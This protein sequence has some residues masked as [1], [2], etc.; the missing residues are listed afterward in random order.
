MPM[1]TGGFA[2]LLTKDFEKIFFDE[3]LRQPEEYRGVA[4]MQTADTHYIREGDMYGLGALREMAE[5][6]PIPFEDFEQ[7]NEKYTYFT[8]FGLGVQMS[9]NMYEDDLTGHMNKPIAEL[10]KASAYTRDLKFWDIFNSG[11]LAAAR[12]GLD[13]L[14]LFST[15]HPIEGVPGLT[16]SN[17]VS[18]S[19][20]QTS[21][22]AAMDLV[23]NLKNDK[24]I[25]IKFIPRTLVVPYGQRWKAEELINSELQPDTANNN[26]NT[27]G[28]KGLNF[29]VGHYLTDANACYLVCDGHDARFINRR[30]TMFDGKDDYNTDAALFKATARFQTTFFHWR[31]IVKIT[32]A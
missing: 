32:G 30:D 12:V 5:N 17:I 4:K 20:S 26:L 31:G 18:A 13:G 25:P 8:N 2:N 22:Q 24:N 6:D 15:A 7:G 3:Y 23:E 16:Q 21:L 9:R 27:T 1:T 19:L 14:A 10:G 11:E 28:N 29:M